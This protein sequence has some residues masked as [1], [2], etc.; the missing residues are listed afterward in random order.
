M[1][2]A[3]L[4]EAEGIPVHGFTDVERRQVKGY[5]FVPHLELSPAGDV[6]IVS[7]ISQRGT[8]NRIAGFMVSRGL[9]EGVDFILAA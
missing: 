9:V 4:L 3:S 8:G 5:T 1:E 2:R 6:F 7:L